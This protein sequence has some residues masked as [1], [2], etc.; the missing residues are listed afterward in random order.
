MRDSAP[1]GSS[2][3]DYVELHVIGD[4]LNPLTLLITLRI[5]ALDGSNM[6]FTTVDR[7]PQRPDTILGQVSWYEEFE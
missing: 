4:N 3:Q 1:D 5:F 6:E 7:L 2:P